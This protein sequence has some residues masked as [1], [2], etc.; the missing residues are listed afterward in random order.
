MATRYGQKT[1][2]GGDVEVVNAAV[3]VGVAIW[4]AVDLISDGFQDSPL[5]T[6]SERGQELDVP[7]WCLRCR[8]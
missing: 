7:F 8:N 1:D 5:V 4:L 3:I 2:E 6:S